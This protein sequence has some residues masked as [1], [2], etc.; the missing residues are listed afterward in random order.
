MSHSAQMSRSAALIQH[1]SKQ[2]PQLNISFICSDSWDA[3]TVTLAA[4][5]VVPARVF[6]NLAAYF[7]GLETGLWRAIYKDQGLLHHDLLVLNCF[8]NRSVKSS[9][10]CLRILWFCCWFYNRS[11]KSCSTKSGVPVLRILWR[12]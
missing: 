2:L 11:V 4:I 3:S 10:S 5:V 9:V 6:T 12:V 8:Y 7:A 1:L